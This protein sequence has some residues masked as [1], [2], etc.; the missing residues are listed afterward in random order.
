MADALTIV[1]GERDLLAPLRDYPGLVA[2]SVTVFSTDDIRAALD[3]ILAAR[4]RFLVMDAEFSASPRGSAMIER[5]H[6]DPG[7]GATEVLLVKGSEVIPLSPGIEQESDSLDWRGTRRVPRI[8][9][10]A[11]LEAQ[12]DGTAAQLVDL[13]T[14]GAQVVSG[15]PLKPNQRVRFNLPADMG[16]RMVAT[17][18]WASFELPKGR[19]LP[20]Y[21]AGLEFTNAN[22]KPLEQ[23][24]LAHAFAEPDTKA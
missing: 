15:M 5:L 17:V 9:M 6:A 4:P 10:Q 7:F 1:V 11:G 19:P 8:R 3:K 14:L 21:R 18:A 12:V 13:S 16:G 23:F 24:C 2:G 22:P 20:Q